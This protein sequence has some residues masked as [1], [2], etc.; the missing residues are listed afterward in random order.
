MPDNAKVLSLLTPPFWA[1]IAAA[2]S[3]AMLGT[4][5]AFER[6]G[7][8]P[9]CTLCYTQ[10]EV[11]WAALGVA[12][13][14]LLGWHLL[15]RN[16]MVARFACG[17]LGVLFL[18]GMGWAIYHAGAEWKYWPGPSTCSGGGGGTGDIL[19]ALNQTTKVIPCDEASWRMLGLS[20]AGWNAIV[21]LGLASV[22][23][24]AAF[25]LLRALKQEK[26]TA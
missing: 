15:K 18:V 24:T 23:F 20:M 7:G 21:S 9:P 4:A 11:Y 16:E 17:I 25:R 19:A 10:R 1:A 8:Y 6:F 3:A 22:S 5:H 12:V 2:A 13:A 14:G 26:A